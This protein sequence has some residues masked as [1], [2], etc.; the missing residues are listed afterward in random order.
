MGLG[1]VVAERPL[2]RIQLMTVAPI[3][4]AGAGMLALESLGRLDPA[5]RLG[6]EDEVRAGVAAGGLR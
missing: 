6:A 2:A 4:G 3:P 5:R 1:R